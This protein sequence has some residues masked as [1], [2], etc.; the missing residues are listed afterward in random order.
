MYFS[1]ERKYSTEHSIRLHYYYLCKLRNL[2]LIF[3]LHMKNNTETNKKAKFDQVVSSIHLSLFNNHLDF[4]KKMAIPKNNKY[5]KDRL[6][7][8]YSKSLSNNKKD[9]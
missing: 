6:Y 3:V 7:D 1:F 5:L 8:E 9:E 4:Y 2:M